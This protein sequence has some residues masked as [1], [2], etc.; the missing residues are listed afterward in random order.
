LDSSDVMWFFTV[1]SATP[2]RSAISRL[3]RPSPIRS[4][5]LSS[6]GVRF[7][8]G[9]SWPARRRVTVRSSSRVRPEATARITSVISAPRT[10]LSR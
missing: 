2:R 6:L 9:S 7:S 4:S 3:D 1:F 5:T 10:L 8:V